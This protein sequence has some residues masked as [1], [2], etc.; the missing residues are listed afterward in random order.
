MRYKKNMW[1]GSLT[2]L[3][4][5]ALGTSLN[6]VAQETVPRLTRVDESRAN[7]ELDGRLDEAIWQQIPAMDGMRVITPDTLAEASLRTETRIFYTERG[8]YVGIMNHQPHESLVTRMTPRDTR[9]ERDGVV[10]D[11]DASG[12]GLF[13]YMMRVNLGDSKTD[14]TISP[15]RTIN[16]QWDGSW[17]AVTSEV[18]GGWVAEYFIPWSMMALPRVSGN[19]RRIGLYVERQVGHL[20]ETWS[21]PALPA[22]VNEFL[23][24]F[25]KFELQD[26]EPRTQLTFYPYVSAT[27]DAVRDD[28]DMRAGAE[29]FWR[30]TTNTQLSASLNPDFGNVESDDVVVN[31]TAYET[32]FPEKRA[33]FLEGQDV[34]ATSPRNQSAR[35]P[36]GPTSM[37]NTRRIGSAALYRVPTGVHVTDTDLSA[38]S[39]LLGALKFTGQNGSLRYGVLAASEDDMAI[40][41]QQADGTEIKIEASGRDFGVGRLLYEDTTGGG[42]RSI[43]WM[44]TSVSHDLVDAVVNG[45]DMHYF[46]ADSRWIFDGQVLASDVN[47]TEGYG[48]IADLIY[49]PARGVSHRIAAGYHDDKLE[50]NT[51]G[52]LTRNDLMHF[53]YNFT[54][55]QSNIEGLRSRNY[56]IFVFNHWNSNNDWVRQGIFGTLEQTYL[57][58]HSTMVSLRYYHRRI[59]DRL[60]RGSGDFY[61]PGRWQL[62]A[63]WDSDPTLPISYGL[64]LD[65]NSE[66]LGEKFL[67]TGASINYRPVSNFSAALELSYVDR[68]GLL[69]YR[70][71]GRYTS[72]EGHQWAPKFTMD[73]FI[74]AHHQLRLGMQWTGLKAFENKFLQVN[75][76][77]IEQLHEVAKPNLTDDSFVISRLSFQARYR[78]EI[79]PLSDLFIVY[80]R[81]GNL[82][83]SAFDDYSGLLSEAWSEPVVDTLVIKLRYRLGS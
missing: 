18:E 61:V 80:T 3:G 15:E 36:G 76:N 65:A 2:L 53:D 13:G 55:D 49:R 1:L 23:S 47:D 63:S 11:I 79:A 28:N 50:L 37:L 74:N 39:D 12:E 30:P 42:R 81:G 48:A 4:L 58:N 17:N 54:R 5:S 24:A 38:P 9:L 21:A 16:L 66:D 27:H 72:F 22:T 14:G 41:G 82:P 26:I 57:N 62:V 25:Q 20:N 51:L 56:S 43:G 19:T 32:F 59:D 60:G 35:G 29:I 68:E 44:G 69:V 46:S 33:F 77:Q 73:Y 64:D 71:N 67:T 75:P 52:F 10:V 31:L 70:G 40:R 6:A 83:G 34:F 78:W 8:I 45:V 7:I